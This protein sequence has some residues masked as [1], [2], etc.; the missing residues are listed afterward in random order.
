MG[1]G[2]TTRRH[3]PKSQ[4]YRLADGGRINRQ[5]PLAFTFNGKGYQGYEGDILASA[6]LAGGVGLVGRS[7]KYHRSRGIVGSGNEEPNALFQIDSG[8]RSTPNLRGTEVEIY[9]GLEA[10][11]VNV[12]PSVNHDISAAVGLF[13]RFLP[14][15][16][17][18]KT[19]MWPRRLWRKYEYFIRKAAGLGVSPKEPDPDEYDR[20][21]V[22][23]DVLVVGGGPA[24]L[25]AALEAGRTGARVI[26]ADEQSELGGSLLASR[27]LID[28]APAMKW[29]EAAVRELAGMEEVR[30]LIRSTVSGYY[31]HNFL[32]ILQRM[33][34][35]LPS[36]PG[37]GPRERVWRVRA[38]HVIIASGAIERPLVFPNN[39]R[40][41][42]M[43]A[44]A[45]STYLNRYAVAPGAR[46]LIFTNN[47]GAYQTALDLADAGVPVAGVVDVRLDPTGPLPRMVRDRGIEV[48]EGHA[49]VDVKGRKRV[50]SVEFMRIDSTGDG[51]E[52]RAGKIRC[53]LVAVSGGWNP[54]VHLHC[55]SGGKARFDV[56]RACFVPDEAVQ[57]ERSV[58]ACNGSFAL[59]E[60]L[61]EGFAAG[62]EAARAAGFGDG[63]A[64]TKIPATDD[65]DQEP[66]RTMWVVPSRHPMTR[67]HKQFVD[68]Q[69]D[70]TAGDIVLSA[71]EGYDSVPLCS[72]Y[73][74]LG[75]GT[76]QGKLGNVNGMGILAKHLGNDIREVGSITFR[77]AYT[78]VSFGAIA[79]RNLGDLFDP[80]RKTAMHQWHVDHG[81]EFENVG[82]W[83]RP[84]Y[85]PQLGE[86]MHSAVNRECLAART[87][88]ALLDQSTLGKIDIQGPDAVEFL[89]RVYTNN[90]R[91]LGIGRCRYGLML[92]E[93]GMVLD[94][95]V[96]ARLGENHFHMFTTTGGAAKVMSWLELWLQTEWPELKV[97]L[98]SVTDHWSTMSIVGPKSREVITKIC[99]DVDFSREVFP[100]LSFKR[101]T[102]A[103]MPARIFRISFTGELTYEVNISANYGRH[104]W[105]AIIEAGQEFGIT[106]YGTET[107]HVL[108]AEKAFIIAGQDTD[109]TVTPIDLGLDWLVSDTKDF[110]GK[111][112]LSRPDTVREDRKQLV[113]LLTDDSKDMLPDGGQIV[114]NHKASISTDMIGHVT[115][116][117]YSA[118]LGHPFALALVKG[119]RA[120]MG[121]KVYVPLSGGRRIRATVTSPVFYDRDGDQ[122]NV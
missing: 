32:T 82:Q 25:A 45:V 81:A 1:P 116:S 47:D 42:V 118:K 70:V 4:K 53:D 31:D 69:E 7:F 66:L 119:G 114:E 57:K 13:S 37:K 49:I 43:L 36:N 29:V 6:L 95:G 113:G 75:F 46:A 35:H 103:G 77:P 65:E 52:G 64:S 102:V 17:Y 120:R 117:Y 101:G 96:T 67:E 41:G 23:C 12:W 94:D 19:F 30:L 112:S 61:K 44:S 105:E 11:S 56:V 3:S 84:W 58:G 33:T 74:T 108:R 121:E 104:V 2:M 111:R 79:G 48:I 92:G 72:R 40:P 22:H 100:F 85:Y 97:F 63:N 91:K 90:W 51:V 18:Y 83:K 55:Q 99:H 9:E 86:D 71:N 62:A 24:G 87:T 5:R 26:L 115:S 50:K 38:K 16:F 122:Q 76:D 10:R 8:A 15:G 54:A 27:K 93:D 106:P 60:C 109:G 59:V 21:N 80:I 20:M 98:T 39:D 34:N 110:L 107:M 89:S 68:L 88:V 28:G 73:T 14:P 78:P